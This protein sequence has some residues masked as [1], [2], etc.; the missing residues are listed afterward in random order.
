MYSFFFSFFYHVFSTTFATAD[1]KRS[2]Q[3]SILFLNILYEAI[4]V[5]LG[6]INLIAQSANGS[7]RCSPLVLLNLVFSPSPTY[8]FIAD[9]ITLFDESPLEQRKRAKERIKKEYTHTYTHTHIYIYIYI[10]IYKDRKCSF[11][12]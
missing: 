1:N 4:L 9:I 11:Y 3:T 8:L 2:P 5:S 6:S 12:C 10:Y 7:E